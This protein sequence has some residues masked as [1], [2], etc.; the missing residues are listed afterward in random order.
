MNQ[1]IAASI[2]LYN[3]QIDRLRDNIVSAAAQTECIVLIDNGSSNIDEIEKADFVVEHC[4]LIKNSSNLG[5]ATALNQA[6][7]WAYENDYDW[8]LT[9]DQDSVCEKS[10]VVNL[11]KHVNKERVG[12]IA[13]K[14][15]DRNCKRLSDSETGW[16][17]ILRCITSASLTNVKIWKEVGEFNEELFID[18]VDYDFCAKLIRSGYAIIKDSDV[19]LIH[20]IGH[21]KRIFVAK[22]HSYILYNHSAMRDYYIVR[23]TLYYCYEYPDVWNVKREKRELLIRCVMIMLFESDKRHKFAAMLKGWKDSKKLISNQKNRKKEEKE[24]IRKK[25]IEYVK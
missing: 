13:P 20:E 14:F 7:Q 5:L 8:V 12:I 21:S 24:E 15:I 4:V 6:M 9:L 23:N 16:K 17:Y 10:L 11:S 18:Y 19:S 25:N 1:S 2:V 22:K 3:P